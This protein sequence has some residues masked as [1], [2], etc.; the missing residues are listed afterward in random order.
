ME[1]VGV[2]CRL[3]RYVGPVWSSDG[4]LSVGE[5][6][7]GLV[8][9][10]GIRRYPLVPGCADNLADTRVVGL[11]KGNGENTCVERCNGGLVAVD[12]MIRVGLVTLHYMPLPTR[13]V[14][15]DPDIYVGDS[16]LRLL[17]LGFPTTVMVPMRGRP[18]RWLVSSC[19]AYAGSH[20]SR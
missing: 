8:E 11:E 18:C 1:E 15:F 12:A 17:S 14:V 19:P 16:K 6:Q 20:G 2:W 9:V 13:T 4:H 3:R 5:C 10:V 7:T